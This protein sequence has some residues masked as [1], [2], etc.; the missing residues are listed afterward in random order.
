MATLA[1]SFLEDLE[2]LSDEEPQREEDDE[3]VKSE[4][5]ELMD[6]EC[7]NL[8]DL[9][10]VAQLAHSD[11]YTSVVKAVNDAI[12]KGNEDD[13]V[14]LGA[15]TE[16]ST[17]KLLVECN[18]LMVDIDNEVAIVSNFIRDKYRLKFPELESLVHHPIDYARVVR[19]IGNE[20]DLTKVELEGI[21]P[22]AT[23]MVVSVTATTTSGRPLSD[24]N[25]EKTESACDLALKLDEDKKMIN[26]F[27]E[28]KMHKIAPNLSTVVGAETASRLMGLA[29]G[30]TELARIPACNIAVLGAKKKLMT[31]YSNTSATIQPH[32]GFVF[33]S[34]FMQT[35]PQNLKLRAAKLIA[36]KAALMARMDEYG[37]DPEGNVGAKMRDEI[38]AK[39]EGWQEPP[40][41]KQAK[42]LPVPDAEAKKRRGGK[43][44]RALKERYRLTDVRKAVNRVAFNQ[45]EEEMI[46]GDE[47]IGLGVMGKEGSGRLRIVSKQQKMKLSSKTGKKYKKYS[48][49]SGATAGVSSSLVF[50][51]VQGMEFVNPQAAA[52]GDLDRQGGTESYFSEFGGFRSIAKK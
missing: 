32:Q 8:D 28:S 34:Q 35:V 21:L 2:E 38:V 45:P 1:D 11:R 22:S 47:V 42:P 49:S 27:V 20:M 44:L 33:N 14:W 37:K 17:Y 15:T 12:Q 5:E 36:G 13:S 9:S 19:Q 16:D 23:I 7:L 24:E 6:V 51:P 3:D 43:R 4:P 30:L 50:T 29:G 48:G 26:S 10:A 18:Q 39:I 31:G 40:P 41:A 46:D 52:A 25:L